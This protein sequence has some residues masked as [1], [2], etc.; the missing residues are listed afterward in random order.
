MHE[1]VLGR[2]EIHVQNN[3][4]IHEQVQCEGV[5]HEHVQGEG[6][7]QEQV[8][9]EGDIQVHVQG[10]GDNQGTKPTRIETMRRVREQRRQATIAR[11]KLEFQPVEG[12]N[13]QREEA[14]GGH[15]GGEEP[16]ARQEQTHGSCWG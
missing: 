8:Q 15:D 3:G 16:G 6:G 13:K 4:E 2:G 1:Q 7:V 11:K 12:Q 10:E 14:A 5:E 9:V